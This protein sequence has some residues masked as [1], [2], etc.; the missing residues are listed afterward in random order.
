M[1]DFYREKNLILLL[2]LK[3]SRIIKHKVNKELLFIGRRNIKSSLDKDSRPAR[4]GVRRKSDPD[5][6][7]RQ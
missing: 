7:E 5:A 3:D 1:N 4:P 6:P 2:S